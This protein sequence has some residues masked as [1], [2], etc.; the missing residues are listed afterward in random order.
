MDNNNASTSR[1]KIAVG[2]I[3]F[4]IEGTEALVKEGMSYAKENLLTE[5]VREI[6]KQLP[7]QSA[8]PPEAVTPEAP[9]I[10]SYYKEK[11][12]HNDM[13]RVTVLTRYAQ[14]YRGISEVSDKELTPLFNEVRGKLP[15]NIMQAIRNAARKQYGFLE[16][17]GKSGYYR[18]TN[19]G[20]N[21]VNSLPQSKN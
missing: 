5:S 1:M 19:A 21:L 17:T 11:N 15:K 3:T 16:A 13:E 20:I 14:I 6:A 4:E 10:D 8:K 18:I 12:P 7:I 9:Q 2:A